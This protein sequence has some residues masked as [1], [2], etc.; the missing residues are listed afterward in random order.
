MKKKGSYKKMGRPKKYTVEKIEEIRKQ[1]EEYI[2]ETDIPILSEFCHKNDIRKQ[3][4]SEFEKES[5]KFSD[6]IKRLHEKEEAQLWRLGFLNIINQS[7]GIFRLKQKPFCY[8]DKQQLEHTGTMNVNNSYKEMSDE[9]L[10]HLAS[11]SDE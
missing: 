5:D 8:S 3:R 9:E 11:Q 10:E 1:I 4:I 7:F 2:E 6:T